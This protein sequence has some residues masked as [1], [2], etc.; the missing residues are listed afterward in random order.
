MIKGMVVR[1]QAQVLI[2][3]RGV[4]GLGSFLSCFFL[5]VQ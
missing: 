3:W 4:V 5:G 2:K 1:K